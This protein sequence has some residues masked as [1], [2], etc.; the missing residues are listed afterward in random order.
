[1]AAGAFTLPVNEGHRGKSHATGWRAHGRRIAAD[2]VAR[3]AW[4]PHASVE[5]RRRI[6]EI[7]R[8]RNCKAGKN[9]S[10]LRHQQ[11]GMLALLFFED[12]TPDDSLINPFFHS[13]PGPIACAMTGN[14]TC[15]RRSSRCPATGMPISRT[16]TAREQRGR[17]GFSRDGAFPAGPW[18]GSRRKP[19][20]QESEA[21]DRRDA[22]D[23]LKS[24]RS[25]PMPGGD[26]SNPSGVPGFTTTP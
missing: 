17:S 18:K 26:I 24:L 1:M 8:Q 11:P 14:S 16:A 3:P 4:R 21:G 19:H 15:R 23:Q 6:L 7:A 22:G 9:A 20:L 5:I 25:S 2:G 10:S 12:P 13:M